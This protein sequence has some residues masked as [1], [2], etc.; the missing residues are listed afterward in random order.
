MREHASAPVSKSH[1]L[2]IEIDSNVDLEDLLN[3]PDSNTRISSLRLRKLWYDRPWNT[4]IPGPSR[5]LQTLVDLDLDYRYFTMTELLHILK[6]TPH[7]QSI[8]IPSVTVEG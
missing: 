2:D 3:H 1:K 7:L 6:T 8:K 5:Q 4:P